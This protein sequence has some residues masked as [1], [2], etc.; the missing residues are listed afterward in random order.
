MIEIGYDVYK[1][2]Y[3]EGFGWNLTAID[4]GVRYSINK[5]SSKIDLTFFKDQDIAT[6]TVTTP[7]KSLH[8]LIFKG[9]EESL[10][11]AATI[12]HRQA[13]ALSAWRV[14]EHQRRSQANRYFITQ[15]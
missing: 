13:S 14:E 4:K 3:S 5:E 6:T 9:T 8:Y 15:H 12:G 1:N 11:A 7:K 10:E 2:V